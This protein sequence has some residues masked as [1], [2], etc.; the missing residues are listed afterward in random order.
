M[1]S[2]ILISDNSIDKRTRIECTLKRE[3]IEENLEDLAASSETGG[4]RPATKEHFEA[5]N[6]S[7]CSGTT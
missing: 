6:K 4:K 3:L 2:N 1:Y 5:V 7:R